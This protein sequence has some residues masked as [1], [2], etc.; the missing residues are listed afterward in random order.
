MALLAPRGGRERPDRRPAGAAADQDQRAVALAQ[1][2]AAERA[3]HLDA[4][5]GPDRRA[6]L[7]RDQAARIAADV[8][9]EL[10]RVRPCRRGAPSG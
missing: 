6:D 8:E 4:V 7:G 1:E 5:A 9:D 2:G 10:A 3:A